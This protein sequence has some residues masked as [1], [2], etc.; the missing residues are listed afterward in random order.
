MSGIHYVQ[1]P[2]I[3]T[4]GPYGTNFIYEFSQQRFDFTVVGLKPNTQ[5]IFYFENV[6]K[7]AKCRQL[8]KNLGVPL[9]TDLSGV[10]QFEFYY[11]T[12]I[13][14]DSVITDY[15]QSQIA[16]QALAGVKQIRI[17]NSDQTSIARDVLIFTMPN[18]LLTDPVTFDFST[19]NLNFGNM[20]IGG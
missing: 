17:E 6:D 19:L 11:D 18:S 3:N 4:V 10:V 1:Q 2:A 8:G 20:G 5:H 15:L 14:G 12:D 9:V 13:P 7:S 16:L